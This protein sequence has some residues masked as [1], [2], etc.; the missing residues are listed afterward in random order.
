M[1]EDLDKRPLPDGPVN[2]P[3]SGTYGERAELDR[4]QKSLPTME[5]GTGPAPGGQSTSAQ[6]VRPA[7]P[8]PEGRPQ[9]GAAAPPGV[10]SVLLA[11]STRPDEPVG[12]PLSPPP[13]AMGGAVT[14]AQRRLQILQMLAESDE[15]SDDTREWAQIVLRQITGG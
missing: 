3:A 6:P 4:L 9:T 12:T 1:A 8:R 11:P 2:R 10:P 14:S 13:M 5:P 15:V 7:P